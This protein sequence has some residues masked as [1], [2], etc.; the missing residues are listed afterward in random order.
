MAVAMTS[1]L[2][3]TLSSLNAAS[4]VVAIC[5]TR[6][7]VKNIPICPQSALC[8]FLVKGIVSLCSINCLVYIIEIES[9]LRGTN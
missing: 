4:E 5:T 8:V 1:D 9:L 6:F 2:D 7:S 3:T